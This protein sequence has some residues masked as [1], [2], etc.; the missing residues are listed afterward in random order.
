MSAVLH[1]LGRRA[2][3]PTLALQEELVKGARSN[4][5]EPAHL[6]LVEHDPPTITFGRR[7]APSHLLAPAA[8]LRELGLEVHTTTRGGSVTWHG[9]G[10]LVAYPILRLSA[11]RTL[12]AHVRGLEEAAIATLSRFGIAAHRAEG[13]TGVWVGDEK[14]AAIGVAVTHWV[15]WHGVALNV[16]P[17][18]E[19]FRLIVPCGLHG[20]RVTS[21]AKLLG[22][23]MDVE[24]VKPVLVDCLAEA[25]GL[26]LAPSSSAR[27]EPRPPRGQNGCST[28]EGGAF[29]AD[30]SE[31]PRFVRNDTVAAR[32]QSAIGNRKSTIPP[33]R[34]RMPAWLRRPIPPSGD[35][36]EIRQILAELKLPTVCAEALCPN[37]HDCFARRAATFMI[38]GDVCTRSCRFCA[39]ERGRPSPPRDDEPQAL[40]EAC[41]RLGLRHVVITSVTRDDLPDGGAS[42]FA[43][44]IRAV[45]ARLPSSRIE[46]L[47]PDFRGSTTAVDTVLEARPEVF[48]HNLETVSRLQRCVRGRANYRDSLAILAHAASRARVANG[49]RWA[50]KSGLMLGLGESPA[51]VVATLRDLRSSGCDMLTVGQYLPPSVKHA[52]ALRFA[53]PSEFA[54]I[55]KEALAMGFTAVSAGPFV[56]S[57]YMAEEAYRKPGP[58]ETGR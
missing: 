8:K 41:A 20:K 7:S 48:S 3:L 45:K 24:E 52:P 34:P 32:S 9:P 54:S 23:K 13:M 25:L 30:G 50:V 36:A 18:L 39:V 22:R 21:M 55:E 57:S 1:D 47:T 58:A 26:K 37:I 44:V 11:R 14:V 56:R 19:P 42:H 15:T 2:Y 46:V 5:A 31:I 27:T 12:R 40:A 17:D 38:L 16:A 35:S 53:D 4:P 28:P 33:P 51:E 10:Q 49:H 29:P 43:R 6:V